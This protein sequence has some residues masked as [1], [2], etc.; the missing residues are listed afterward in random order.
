MVSAAAG[1]PNFNVPPA[2]G[3]MLHLIARIAG[4]KRILEIGALGG[5]SA[6]WYRDVFP[7]QGT[8]LTRDHSGN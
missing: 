7:L 8:L 4:A 5:Y 2:Q 3:K 1:M 6:I